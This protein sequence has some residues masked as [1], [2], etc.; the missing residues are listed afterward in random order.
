MYTIYLIEDDRK[1]QY[2]IQD[3]LEKYQFQVHVVA[4]FYS[5]E[6]EF[7]EAVPD[8]VLLDINL[9]VNDGYHY[10]RLFRRLSDVPI[11]IISARDSEAEQIMGMEFGADDYMVKPLK[12]PLLV[13]KMHTLIRR[14]KGGYNQE[15]TRRIHGLHID[16]KTFRVGYQ[17]CELDL[18]K[19]EFGLLKLLM[20]NY[21]KVVK[22]EELLE[23]LWD[24]EYFVDD[25]TLTVNVTRVKSKLKELGLSDVITTKRGVGYMLEIS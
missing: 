3:Y 1:L 15:Y 9:P 21:S 17:G 13:A 20:D 8:L 11:I 12:L 19:K 23:L 10:C 5:I 18:T 16:E 22:R 2:Y 7:R 4:D 25:N 14:A 6:K 24:S